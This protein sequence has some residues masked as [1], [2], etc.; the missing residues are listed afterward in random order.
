MTKITFSICSFLVCFHVYGQVDCPEA[1]DSNQDGFIGVV[2]L[3]NLLSLFGDEDADNDGIFDSVDECVGYFDVCGF[4][5]GPGILPGYD[6]CEEMYGPCA[7][8]DILEYSGFSYNLV[9]IGEDCWFSKNLRVYT[10]NNGDSLSVFEG[11]SEW[12]Q[13]TEAA[14]SILNNAIGNYDNFGLLYNGYVLGDERNVCPQEWHVATESDW[15]SLESYIGMSPADLTNGGW[16]G[17]R[18]EADS[19]GVRLKSDSLWNGTNEYGFDG[20]NGYCRDPAGNFFFSAGYY[21]S[22]GLWWAAVESVNGGYNRYLHTS[23][24]GIYRS[25]RQGNWGFYIRCVKD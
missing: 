23:E 24:S 12:S 15:Q 1:L 5:N 22:G 8:E 4:C 11:A 9:P 14:V 10:F 3:M 17:W 2:D 19:L 25:S 16:D 13:T 21:A 7:G 20:L 18:G 6:S